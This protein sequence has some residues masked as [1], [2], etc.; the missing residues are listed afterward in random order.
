MFIDVDDSI[1]E[2]LPMSLRSPTL[3]NFMKKYNCTIDYQEFDTTADLLNKVHL[4]TYY[5]DII[6]SDPLTAQQLYNEQR[7]LTITK[8]EAPNRKFLDPK[9]TGTEFTIDPD[10][11]APYLVGTTGILYWKDQVKAPVVS[12]AQYFHPSEELKGSMHALN[13]S[14]MV[15]FALIYLVSYQ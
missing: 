5:Y 12:W 2:S 14:S 1:D 7:L 3:L 11:Y 10:F 6:V 15:S 4:A 9:Y 8:N 13:E